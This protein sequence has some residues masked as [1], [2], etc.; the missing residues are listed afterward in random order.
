MFENKRF[1]CERL[2]CSTVQLL[3]PSDV[4]SLVL[5]PI[6][7]FLTFPIIIAKTASCY[8]RGTW[9][10]V[11]VNRSL[12]WFAHIRFIVNFSRTHKH[13]KVN[14]E[15]KIR[16][17]VFDRFTPA[18][19]QSNV[20]VPIFNNGTF[21]N[22]RLWSETSKERPSSS[23][24]HLTLEVKMAVVQRIYFHTSCIAIISCLTII[25]EVF[26]LEMPGYKIGR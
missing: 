13:F 5:V 15:I 4:F 24:D 16:L 11:L 21:T 14:L 9:T 6:L 25:D 1:V 23:K 26:C 10:V 2:V 17:N 3:C 19:L 12:F 8:V 20:T 7:I 22:I 18:S